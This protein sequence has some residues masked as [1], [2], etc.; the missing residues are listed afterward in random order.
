[1]GMVAGTFA[2]DAFR[3]RNDDGNE[4]TATWKAAANTNWTQPLNTI[5]RLRFVIKQTDSAFTGGVQAFQCHYSHN[6]G[7]YTEV[8]GQGTTT[9]AVRLADSA[10]VADAAVTT[11][12]IGTGTFV[13]GEID[14]S[15]FAD[16][17]F[18]SG[19][20][21]TEFEFVLEAISSIVA[22]GDTLDFRVYTSSAVAIATYTVTP[23]ATVGAGAAAASLIFN[24][25][26]FQPFLV[27]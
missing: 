5:F 11:Q 19:L 15:G 13:A 20:S 3:A 24:P 10:N 12:Q 17:T 1:M 25:R 14:E 9:N 8:A 21:E 4:T 23:R 2:Q 26:P 18:A 6:G 27:R 7:A 22:N 16:A